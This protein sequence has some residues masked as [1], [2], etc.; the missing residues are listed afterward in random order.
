MTTADRPDE[1]LN[2]DATAERDES[3]PALIAAI[4]D[5][6]VPTGRIT[7]AQFMDLAL[8][9]P[10]HGYYRVRAERPGRGGDFLTAPELSPFFGTCIA[11]QL[12]EV[13]QLLGRPES[14]TVL[15]YGAGGGRLAQDILAGA[16]DEAPEFAAALRY[17][18]H[19]TNP[20]RRASARAL[21]DAT[22]L[23]E[24]VSYEDPEDAADTT[25]FVGAIITNEFADALPI[26]RVIGDE[27]GG[28]R[29]R[30][31]RWD[32]AQ[33]WFAEELGEPSTPRLVAALAAG[34]ITLQ[35]GQSA[36]I[37]L[38]AHDWLAGVAA[39]LSR[40]L[41]LTIDYGYPTAELYAPKRRNGTFL[42]YYRHTANEAPYTQIGQQDMT[43]H[44]DFGALERAGSAVGLHTLGFTTQGHFLTNL[45][46]GDLLVAT[47]TP[48]RALDAYL[49]DRSAVL[50]LIEPGGMGRFGVLAQG[51]AFEPAVPLR[52]FGPLVHR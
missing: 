7:F 29:E 17:R 21:L 30:Y 16:R 6:I 23:G 14:F 52:G 3:N 12:H 8:Y 45:G 39:R 33:G 1:Q 46:L 36:E 44:V 38:A 18:L 9:H 49:T 27:A 22:R 13:W 25:A 32:D 48:G 34:G 20:H 24:V 4:R 50:A 47:Q 19:E 51:K 2:A 43:A 35:A 31:V 26:H 5:A 10:T 11:R 15:E 41:L 40:G 42:C 37:N 28:I